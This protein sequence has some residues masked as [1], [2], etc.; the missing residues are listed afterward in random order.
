MVGSFRRKKLTL[1]DTTHG[2][3]LNWFPNKYG[4]SVDSMIQFSGLTSG[5]DVP[6]HGSLLLI[7]RPKKL[8]EIADYFKSWKESID[9]LV[10]YTKTERSKMFITHWLYDDLRR[11]C[12]SMVE[13]LNHYVKGS[14]R[15]WIPRRFTQDPIESLFGQIRSINGSNTNLDRIGVDHGFSEIRSKF[16][17][18]LLMNDE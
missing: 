14:K 2:F 11:T 18:L 4:V 12:Y 17:K 7:D 16:L 6:E 5:T 1:C 3:S 9:N 10:G 13:L 15:V 8:L